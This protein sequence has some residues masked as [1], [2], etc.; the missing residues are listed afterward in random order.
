MKLNNIKRKS[1]KRKKYSFKDVAHSW[2][3][4]SPRNIPSEGMESSTLFTDGPCLYFKYKSKGRKWNMPDY[5]SRLKLS[6]DGKI[7]IPLGRKDGDQIHFL[8]KCAPFFIPVAR[9]GCGLDRDGKIYSHFLHGKPDFAWLSNSLEIT[10]R[11]EKVVR[12][13]RPELRRNFR[14]GNRDA[15]LSLII[16][17]SASL[18]RARKNET[19]EFFL[20]MVNCLYDEA[21]TFELAHNCSW[22][23][24]KPD[25]IKE[26]EVTFEMQRK[27]DRAFNHLLF[28]LDKQR[29]D[30][31]LPALRSWDPYR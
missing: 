14:N 17:A 7:M 13:Y 9:S 22:N 27:V 2:R 8:G 15:F 18:K 4:Y 19:K 30:V 16:E 28:S 5:M 26:L 6:T 29:Y 31:G 1:N 21:R 11:H 12:C 10:T 3:Y 24:E 25:S 20:A 23:L